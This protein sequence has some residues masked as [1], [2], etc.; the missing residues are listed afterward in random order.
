MNAPPVASPLR[1][2]FRGADQTLA[3]GSAFGVPAPQGFTDTPATEVQAII[4]AVNGGRPWRDEISARFRRDRPWL[5]DIILSPKR[6][7]FLATVAPSLGDRVLDIGCGWGQL[8]L[9]IARERHAVVALEPVAERLGFV[10]AAARQ[11]QCADHIAFVG[12]DYLDCDFGPTFSTVLAIG[13][14]EWAGAFQDREDPQTRQQRFLQKVRRE[15]KRGGVL[16]VGIENRMGL[17]YLLGCPDDHIGVAGIACLPADLARR[18]WQA[19][20]GHPLRSFTYSDTELTQRLHEAGFTQ[21]ELF[22]ALPDYKLPET[23]ISVS[24]GGKQLNRMILE[25]LNVP[26]H[27]GY[28]GER[29]DAT[30]QENLLHLYR[31]LAAQG[32]AHH[33]APSFFVRAT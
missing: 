8:T 17:K 16:V 25:G 23:V 12:A 27:N 11:E 26:E 4:A 20:S 3:F 10:Q 15:L 7:R 6:S 21:V 24:D 14:L 19:H 33:F 1:F 22:A 5:H 28:D 31:S 32:I 13:V 9:P 18:R 2:H 29:L 30:Q